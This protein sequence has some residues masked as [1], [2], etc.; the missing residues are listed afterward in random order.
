MPWSPFG[1]VPKKIGREGT[2]KSDYTVNTARN[3]EPEKEKKTKM[4]TIEEKSPEKKV[5]EKSSYK[6]LI[7]NLQT[8]YP[9]LSQ[10]EA[11]KGI[12]ALRVE[13][14]GTLTGMTML[15][16]ME[17]V[18]QLARP[19]KGRKREELEPQEY[20]KTEGE[21][22]ISR[23]GNLCKKNVEVDIGT[24]GPDATLSHGGVSKIQR[25]DNQKMEAMEQE[26]FVLEA[27]E[28][29]SKIKNKD[30]ETYDPPA[31]EV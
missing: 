2:P 28:T 12:L 10:E 1:H 9:D 8:T 4:S 21:K 31:Q 19:L 15:E 5:K 20:K 27:E 7:S 16:I 13:N 11:L 26:D 17:R 30:E 3:I 6:K 24:N 25:E 22:S 29:Q 14:N 23:N 18:I